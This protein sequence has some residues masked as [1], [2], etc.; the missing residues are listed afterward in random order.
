MRLPWTVLIADRYL[1]D[2]EVLVAALEHDFAVTRA[3]AED[4]AGADV[5]SL[6]VVIL[7][8]E[9][10]DPVF[11][12]ANAG[13]GAVGLLYDGDSGTLRTRAGHPSVRL[14]AARST[15]LSDLTGALRDVLNGSER[16]QLPAQRGPDPESPALSPRE[17][18]VLRLM[19]HGLANKDI[20]ASLDISPHTV[21]THVQSVLAK[22]NKTSRVSV[23][24]AARTAGYLSR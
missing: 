3:K 13:A 8:A 9:C 12:A 7:D 24:G 11:A 20:A 10:A 14:V 4:L 21:R 5:S 2:S 6:G 17:A 1:V 18:E 19:S 23:V 22:F 15:S 16:R